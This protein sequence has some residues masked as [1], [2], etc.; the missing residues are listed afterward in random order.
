[1]VA[2]TQTTGALVS[3]GWHKLSG[4]DV[5]FVQCADCKTDFPKMPDRTPEAYGFGVPM[6]NGH[7]ISLCPW[8]RPDSKPWTNGRGL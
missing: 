7:M 4:D 1:M 3:I 5:E 8:C 6:C 2:E